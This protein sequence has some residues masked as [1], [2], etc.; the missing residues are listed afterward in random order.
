MA[1]Y[2]VSEEAFMSDYK[3]NVGDLK[4]RLTYGILGVQSVDDYSYLT[5]Y[6]KQANRYGFNNSSLPGI[7]YSIGNEMITWE[8]SANF[9]I[10]FDATFLRNSLDV[11]FDWF[12]KRTYDILLVPVVPRVFGTSNAGTQNLGEMRN[13]GWEVSLAYRIKTGAFA[14]RASFNIA[15]SKNEM[16]DFGGRE[17]ITQGEETWNIIREG[18]AIGSYLGYKSDG[19]FQSYEE[20]AASAIHVGAVVHPGDVKYV[21]QNGDGV[22]NEDDRIVL[23]N[24]FPRYTFGLTYNVTWKAFDLNIMLQGVGKR[25]QMIR[26]EMV[27]PFHHD[28]WVSTMYEHQTDF[29]TPD[30]PGAKN[31]RLATTGTSRQNNWQRIGTDRYMFNMAYVRIKDIRLTY[32]VP[33]QLISKASIA[34]ARISLNVQNPFTFSK[35]AWVDPESTNFGNTMGGR[36]GAGAFLL[37]GNYPLLRYYGAS[38][39]LEF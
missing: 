9:N 15:D 34:R 8:S 28:Y 10:G 33:K 24:A 30:N 6:T 19:L 5:T 3:K 27:E 38:I 32:T 29:W 26:G 2:R 39:D 7:D 22:I 36:S 37:R 18:E 31:P 1:A 21:D 14:H 23:G 13:R 17:Q 12:N 11:S 25:H 4:L 16:T 35:Q 20:I